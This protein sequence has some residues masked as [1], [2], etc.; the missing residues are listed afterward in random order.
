MRVA[1]GGAGH[2]DLQVVAGNLTV[3][4]PDDVDLADAA[5][6]TVAS[7]ALHGLRLADVGPGGKVCVI[8]LGLIGQLTVRLAIA[9]GLDVVGIDLREWAGE[10]CQRGRRAGV[11]RAG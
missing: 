3:A 6:A 2:G 7:I 8:G 9:S 4:V 5:F 11:G 10:V 1:T